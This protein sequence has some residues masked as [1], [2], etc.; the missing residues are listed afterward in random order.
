LTEFYRPNREQLELVDEDAMRYLRGR[1]GLTDIAYKQSIIPLKFSYNV[2]LLSTMYGKL[3]GV[4]EVTDEAI[5][6]IKALAE[7]MAKGSV[8]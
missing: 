6:N 5:S 3:P 4:S 2:W 1:L 8:E 7:A